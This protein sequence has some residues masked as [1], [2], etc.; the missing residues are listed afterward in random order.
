MG[1]GKKVMV[2]YMVG[3]NSPKR[4]NEL[5]DGLWTCGV[6]YYPEIGYFPDKGASS[7][8]SVLR[9]WGEGEAER[10]VGVMPTGDVTV[11]EMKDWNTAGWTT[12]VGEG[13]AKLRDFGK[14]LQLI[15]MEGSLLQAYQ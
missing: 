3:G 8:D 15:E 6:R 13:D 9:N 5:L 14:E 11:A 1:F 7:H 12:F 10:H 4:K 2:V